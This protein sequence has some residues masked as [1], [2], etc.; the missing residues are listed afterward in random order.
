MQDN[1]DEIG[2]ILAGRGARLGL[3]QAEPD[4]GPRRAGAAD[5]AAGGRRVFVGGKAERR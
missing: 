3:Q 2:D 1:H 5:A 4:P